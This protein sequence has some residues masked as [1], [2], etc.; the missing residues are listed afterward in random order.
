MDIKVSILVPIYKSEKYIEECLISLFEQTY[1][2][3]EYIL[4]NDATPD[5]S[6]DIVEQTICKYPYR[7]DSVII[8]NNVTNLGVADTRNIL[9]NKATGDYIYYVDSDDFIQL[10]TIATLVTIA[11]DNK[12]DIVRCNFNSYIDNEPIP[13]TRKPIEKDKNGDYLRDCLANETG[14]N[15]LWLLLIR[16]ALI[17]DHDLSFSK[18]INGCEDFLMT[19]KLLYFANV[20]VD[21]PLALYY[22]RSDNIVSITHNEAIFR[23]DYIKAVCEIKSFL[24][25]KGIY[26]RYTNELQN[27]M[28]ISK[29][30]FLLNKA[31]RYIDKYINTFPESNNCYKSYN[32]SLKEKILFFLANHRYKMIHQNH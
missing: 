2:N 16:R 9:L 12:A 6:M 8:I 7:S 21:T 28:F 5:N 14:M 29:Q 1:Q 10:D 26:D 32:Y 27:L 25:E 15:A 23:N 24:T 11:H 22:Y 4:V 30:K 3:I 17:I 13:I 20:I 19:I 31:I 18:G